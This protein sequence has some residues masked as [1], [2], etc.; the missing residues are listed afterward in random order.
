MRHFKIV[1]FLQAQKAAL[2]T[3]R[4]SADEAERSELDGLLTDIAAAEI[5]IASHA[6]AREVAREKLGKWEAA[7]ALCRA[8]LDRLK[9]INSDFES[10]Q[11]EV[12]ELREAADSAFDAVMQH[13]D[14]IPRATDYPT[15]EEIAEHA[16]EENRLVR[17]HQDALAKLR[18]AKDKQGWLSAD[19]LK[20]RE[21]LG[22][23]EFQERQLRA[24]GQGPEPAEVRGAVGQFSRV[25]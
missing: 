16:A 23:L 9:Q 5:L 19:L 10:R 4:S 17:A 20:A 3:E 12:A 24:P 11:S 25:G 8:A 6:A 18:A 2:S 15:A 22:R 13:R 7:V 1:D 14:R 21:E